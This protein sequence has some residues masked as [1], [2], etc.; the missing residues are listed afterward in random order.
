MHRVTLIAYIYQRVYIRLPRRY[1][2]VGHVN[3]HWGAF[4]KR[5]I[6]NR[7]IRH[8][9]RG[10]CQSCI[11]WERCTF[12]EVSCMQVI[13]FLC[14]LS[15]MERFLGTMSK[16]SCPALSYYMTEG[17]RLL[18][19]GLGVVPAITYLC[20][21]YSKFILYCYQRDFMF[22][23]HKS[24]H[25]D[26]IDMFNDTSWYLDYIFT[27][28]KPEFEKRIPDIYPPELKL[29][30]ANTS[31]K[32]T[33]FLD[34]N[35]KVFGREIHTS[36]YDKRDDFGFPIVNCPWLSGD[37]PRLPSYGIYILQLVR[38]TRC[39]TSVLDFH[40]KNL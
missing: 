38:F 35:I 26:I 14:V 12:G 13:P 34:L 24:K 36:V 37:V 2:I 20:S 10:R 22:D 1:L 33:S 23:L 32:E 21:T 25:V 7:T 40:Y 9:A 30:K 11:A 28:R 16:N 5:C 39:C 3:R 27:I 15:W 6:N 8:D 17:W 31:D 4:A 29:N 19:W 18:R